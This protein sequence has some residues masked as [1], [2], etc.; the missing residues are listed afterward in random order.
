MSGEPKAAQPGCV[1]M[2]DL[3]A[4]LGHDAIGAESDVDAVAIAETRP[5]DLVVG[6]HSPPWGSA[7]RVVAA[8]RGAQPDVPALVLVESS[9]PELAFDRAQVLRKRATVD[10]LLAAVSLLTH[11]AE[12]A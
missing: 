10:E 7:D 5:L 1:A 12:R 11:H 3:L 4:E 9:A 2:C 6:D 8:V